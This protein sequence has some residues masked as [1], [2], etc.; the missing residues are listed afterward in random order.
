MIVRQIMILE[1]LAGLTV[2]EALAS[3]ACPPRVPFSFVERALGSLG[4]L[5]DEMPG[6]SK[7]GQTSVVATNSIQNQSKYRFIADSVIARV[8]RDLNTRQSAI[9]AF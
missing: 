7:Y 8:I 9:K 6:W 2:V 1:G 4:K 3:S 5:G